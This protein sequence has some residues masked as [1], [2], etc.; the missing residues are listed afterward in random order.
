MAISEDLRKTLTDPTPLYAVA[1]T[2]D[3]AVEKLRA[4]PALI[5]KARSEAPERIQ[6]LRENTAPAKV[7]ERAKD[8][9][10]KFEEV[11]SSLDVR[12]FRDAAQGFAL[13]QV[14]R[15]F[16]AA[17]EARETY[18]ELAERG[19]G[20]VNQLR[21][22][23]AEGVEN[24]AVAIEPEA[25]SKAA[26]RPAGGAAAKNEGTVADRVV[27]DKAALDKATEGEAVEGAKPQR[28]TSRSA[29]GGSAART[30][31]AR[32]AAK[33]STAKTSTARTSAARSAAARGRAA[34]EKVEEVE[35]AEKRTARKVSSRRPSQ[36]KPAS[37]G[38]DQ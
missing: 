27:P 22:E 3:L 24:V 21:G 34:A 10:A 12:Q 18:D 9:Q 7:T 31:A 37:G 35:K 38:S 11:V 4:V 14:G 13:R 23:A 28:R 32:T 33:T 5:E 29:A 6:A 15:A 30:T 16:E 25:P 2:A 8:A 36:R 20:V 1:G 26:P 19:R 17:V